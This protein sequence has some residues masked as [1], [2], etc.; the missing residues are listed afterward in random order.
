MKKQKK[1][2]KIRDQKP[3][4]DPKGGRRH[5]ARR[6]QSRDKGEPAERPVRPG[7]IAP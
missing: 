2:I 4:S 3:L 1:G 7:H 6:I 5:H